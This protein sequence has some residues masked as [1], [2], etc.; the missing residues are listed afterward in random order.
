MVVASQNKTIFCTRKM[1]SSFCD[2]KIENSIASV[3]CH[4]KMHLCAKFG[5]IIMKG[6]MKLVVPW[7][8][9]LKAKLVVDDT[10]F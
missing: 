9:G 5:C 1:E 4:D 7:S 3:V 2:N 10:N 6:S 8:S